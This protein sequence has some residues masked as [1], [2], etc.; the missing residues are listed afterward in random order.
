MLKI[1]EKI[2]EQYGEFR[3]NHFCIYA[4]DLSFR[5][6]VKRIDNNKFSVNMHRNNRRMFLRY[7]NYFEEFQLLYK[8]ITNKELS[9]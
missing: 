8:S 2:L 7:I 6:Y 1:T 4:P 3:D 5:F 9:L